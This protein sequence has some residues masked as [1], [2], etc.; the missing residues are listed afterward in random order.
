MSKTILLTGAFGNIGQGTLKK[1]LAAGHQVVCLDRKTAQTEKIADNFAEKIRVVWGDIGDVAVLAKALEGVDTVVHLVGIIPPL[2]EID[3]E[4]AERVNVGGTKSVIEAMGKFPGTR[5][6]IF[7]ST[8]GVF[9]KVQDRVPPLTNHSTLN[10]D[11]NYGRTKVAA[12]EAIR[13]SGLDWTILRI[14]AAPPLE[15]EASAAHD[16]SSLFEM[17][18]DARLEFIHPDDV[19]RAFCSA[20]TCDAAVGKILFLGGGTA[21]QMTGLEFATNMIKGNGISGTLPAKAFKPCATPEFYGDWV[22]TEESQRLLRFQRFTM[23]DF[24]QHAQ[25]KMRWRYYLIRLISPL[26]KR[27]LLKASPYF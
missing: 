19:S 18:A 5:R 20:V 8:F 27:V 17:S 11:D 14:C 13:T 10:P 3:C 22:D 24:V 7:A 6:L 23:D 1:M 25:K 4:L 26:A 15:I 16:P 12:E 2:S 21:C 9:G